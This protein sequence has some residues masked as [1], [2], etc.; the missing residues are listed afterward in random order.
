MASDITAFKLCALPIPE[1]IIVIVIHI[2]YTR[3]YQEI[4][5]AYVMIKRVF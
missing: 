1:A 3:S 5:R 2:L 4:F